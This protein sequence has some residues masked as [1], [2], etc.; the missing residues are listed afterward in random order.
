MHSFFIITFVSLHIYERYSLNEG[1]SFSLPNEKV[2]FPP[3]F[4]CLSRSSL[5]SIS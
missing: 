2:E 1:F 4:V 3:H 5:M